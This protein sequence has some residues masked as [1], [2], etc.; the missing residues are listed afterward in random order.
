LSGW[1]ARW[2]ATCGTRARVQ[3]PTVLA[4]GVVIHPRTRSR[5]AAAP[6][7]GDVDY[8]VMNVDLREISFARTGEPGPGAIGARSIGAAASDIAGITLGIRALFRG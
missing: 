4:E 3:T 8:I 2:S 6:G 1:S 5:V 7:A